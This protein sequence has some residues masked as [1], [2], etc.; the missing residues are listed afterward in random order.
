MQRTR[1]SHSQL[2]TTPILVLRRTSGNSPV[3]Y[4]SS[5]FRVRQPIYR[6]AVATAQKGIYWPQ[7]RVA[8]A[9]SEPPATLLRKGFLFPR[10]LTIHAW[11]IVHQ[12]SRKIL[13]HDKNRRRKYYVHLDFEKKILQV[14][15]KFLLFVK[16]VLVMAYDLLTLGQV[17]SRGRVKWN[18][19]S[20]YFAA[21]LF[22]IRKRSIV[23]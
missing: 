17:K 10:F 3:R 8:P 14:R 4:M 13:I 19:A 12:L 15:D 16:F 1:W 2:I 18:E 23:N 9:F 7:V 21:C 20:S 5:K 6:E 22:S 11:R